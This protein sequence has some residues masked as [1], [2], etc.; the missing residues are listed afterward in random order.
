LRLEL[1]TSMAFYDLS[2]AT[3]FVANNTDKA[4]AL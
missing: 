4:A 3:G 2:K 1:C